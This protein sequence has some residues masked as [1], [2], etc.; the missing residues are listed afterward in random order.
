MAKRNQPSTP[1]E[2]QPRQA[3]FGFDLDAAVGAMVDLKSV[4]P[5]DAFTAE[6]LGRERRGHGVVVNADG[7]VLTIGYLIIEAETVWLTSN[8]GRIVQGHALAFDPVSGFGL[9]QALAPLDLPVARFGMAAAVQPGDRLVIA[10]AG[11]RDHAIV[12]RLAARQEFAGYW[13][14]LLEAA[15]FTAPS[16]PDW[17]GAGVFD[18]TGRLIGVG[19]L[20]IE[21]AEPGRAKSLLNM[22]V[23]IDLLTPVMSDL[24]KYGRA[25]G[26]ARPWLGVYV[27]EMGERL[28]I[29]GVANGGPAE[30]AGIEGGDILMA[31]AGERPRSLADL[32]RKVWSLGPAGVEI[33]LL[34]ERD[35][36]IFEAKVKS[37]DR[38]Q[39]FKARVLH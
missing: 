23:P 33:P 39:M 24:V 35:A 4:A 22:V 2:L 13:E 29:A 7:L 37:V 8:E 19:S 5:A 11:G 38:L 26:P 14:Y 3:D 12:A 27:I 28:V 21:Q 6:T 36:R 25:Q 30:Q 32:W 16:H 10:G 15:L 17:G 20:Q 31:V 9:V 18:E 1:T 34:I